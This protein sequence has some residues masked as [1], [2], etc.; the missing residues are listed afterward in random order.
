MIAGLGRRKS[1]LPYQM[2]DL[3]AEAFDAKR[4]DTMEGIYHRGQERA[5]SGK[6][7]LPML[8]EQ[9]GTPQLAEEKKAALSRVFAIILWG[10]LAAWKIAAQLA[11]EIEPLEAKL[12]ATSQ[13]H[14]EAR[15]FYTM[16]DYL[17]LLGY[18]PEQIDKH[19]ERVLDMTIRTPSLAHKVC[20]MQ[21]MIETIALTIFQ[22]IRKNRVEPVLSEL[23]R[24][25]EIDEA[26]HVGLGVQYLPSLVRKMSWPELIQLTLFQLKVIFWVM[27]SLHSRQDDLRTIGIDPRELIERGKAKQFEVF[28]ETWSDL[29]IDLEANR[30]VVSRLFEAA[31]ELFFADER[32]RPVAEKVRRAWA[33]AV[34]DNAE[35]LDDAKADFEEQMSASPLP[36]MGE[37]G[38]AWVDRRLKR[39]DR[40]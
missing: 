6:E 37:A 4:A 36:G 11:D 13:A 3:A 1:K 27:M 7:I 22:T 38:R 21:L 33:H 15:H 40:T 19:S 20:G 18:V 14:D 23:L 29:G 16:Y 10:E 28:R 9:Y 24:Y 31:S 17:K 39:E 8:V 12:A 25:F 2:F 5:W 35:I 30:P 34:S 32:D 26:R